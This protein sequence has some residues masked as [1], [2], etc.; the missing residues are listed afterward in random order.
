M[1][2]GERTAAEDLIEKCA[3]FD[4]FAA[5]RDLPASA[6]LVV[7][8]PFF[9]AVIKATAL[10]AAITPHRLEDVSSD[11]GLLAGKSAI[12]I[13]SASPHRHLIRA[14]SNAVPGARVMSVFNDW[15]PELIATSGL[16]Q[17]D[18][19]DIERSGR[20]PVPDIRYMIFALPRSGSYYLC[21]LLY[22]AGLGIPKEHLR[23][24]TARLFGAVPGFRPMAFADSLVRRTTRNGYFGTKL[25]SQYLIE[26]ATERSS[27]LHMLRRWIDRHDIRPIYLE[28]RDMALQAVSAVV[29]LT[30]NSWRLVDPGKVTELRPPEY[31][32]DEIFVLYDL[33]RRQR[34]S[35]EGFLDSQASVHRLSY[36]ELDRDP[37]AVLNGVL[38]Y[39]DAPALAALPAVETLKVRN[40]ATLEFAERF[41][42]DLRRRGEG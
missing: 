17:V 37:L 22:R 31:D 38:G 6:A 3:E 41:R 32:F 16:F 11:P 14:F 40:D 8:A 1:P 36:E 12:Y 29:A 7:E 18:P 26:V 20:G 28:R 30:R 34:R 35:L 23:P 33:F 10:R 15:L 25:I 4:L 19:T 42:A 5:I 27:R 2:P 21:E 24:A 13:L 39:L 9:P